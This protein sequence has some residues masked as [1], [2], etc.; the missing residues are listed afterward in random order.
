[1]LTLAI[2]ATADIPDRSAIS[3]WGRT[4][5]SIFSVAPLQF[6]SRPPITPQPKP[7][8]TC[9]PI[10][11]GLPH[12]GS[13]G[14]CAKITPAVHYLNKNYTILANIL[15]VSNEVAAEF[16]VESASALVL[17][18]D[19]QARRLQTPALQLSTHCGHQ[20]HSKPTALKS[21]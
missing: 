18:K 14:Q 3:R 2:C 6:G 13:L 7:V 11:R 8:T 20:G 1:M 21:A 19:P 5:A 15:L 10:C 12:S 16:F 4:V 9:H 17:S